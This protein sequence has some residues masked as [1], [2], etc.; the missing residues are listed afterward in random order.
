MN[1]ISVAP[2]WT[3]GVVGR[4]QSLMLHMATVIAQWKAN[5]SCLEGWASVSPSVNCG[6]RLDDPS[7]PATPG[8]P[9]AGFQRKR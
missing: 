4:M 6:V 8:C 3:T 9:I 7:V 5:D 2:F 1:L